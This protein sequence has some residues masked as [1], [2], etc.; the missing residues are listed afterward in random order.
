MLTPDD[1]IDILDELLVAQNQSYELG[2][3]LK[4]PQHEVEGIHSTYSKP[5]SRLLQV[6]IEFTKQVEPRPTWMVIIDALRSPAVNLPHLARRVEEAHFPSSKPK[7]RV[8]M[9]ALIPQRFTKSKEE[10]VSKNAAPSLTGKAFMRI[11]WCRYV[12][13]HKIFVASPDAFAEATPSIDGKEYGVDMQLF[14]L[15]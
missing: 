13:N 8:A 14:S 1:A 3:R 11:I 4:I 15:S 10:P 2:L 7:W 9:D 6:L 12:V 5:R